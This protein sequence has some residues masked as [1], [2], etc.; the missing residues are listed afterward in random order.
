MTKLKTILAVTLTAF[1]LLFIS[2]G[3]SKLDANGCYIDYDDAVAAANKKNQDIMIIVTL[4]GEDEEMSSD[5]LNK[6][7]RDE[8][9]KK[10]VAS[11][12]SVVCMDFSQK[13]YEATVA[14]EDADEAAKKTAEKNAS[15]MQ[16]N[17]NIAKMLN[18]S[19]TPVI[20]LLSKEQYFING[21][22]YDDENRS[23]EGF[24]NIL[25]EKASSI[26]DMHKMIYQTKIGTAE[27]KI[28]SIDALYNA[29]NPDYLIFLIDLMESVI[30]LDPEDKSGLL[31]KYLY[32][33]NVAKSNK[34]L[35]EGDVKAAIQYYVDISED[36]RISSDIRQY[37][38]YTAA[39]MLSMSELEPNTVVI[40]YLERSI[41]IAPDSEQVP[42]IRRVIEALSAEAK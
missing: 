18:I 42:S 39:Y 36:E 35:I 29:T 22:Y 15:L 27:E 41:Q 32:E 3:E 23:L 7:V 4:E 14:A 38:L 20:F 10:E 2:C 16:K 1:A 12:Y 26:E 30:K 17:T 33:V 28:A 9:F 21:F 24:K 37:A 31:S 6:V 25:A 5:F 34:A 13:S 40:D 11:S 8:N 19:G